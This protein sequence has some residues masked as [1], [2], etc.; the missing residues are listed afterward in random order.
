MCQLLVRTIFYTC[1]YKPSDFKHYYMGS[2]TAVAISCF[3]V[4]LG[5]VFC[6]IRQVGVNTTPIIPS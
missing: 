2:C 4:D 5:P 1:I 6:L 3:D